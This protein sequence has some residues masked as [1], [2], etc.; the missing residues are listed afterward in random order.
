MFGAGSFSPAFSPVSLESCS[1][2]VYNMPSAR[3]QSKSA[4][5]D[6][7]NS[8]ITKLTSEYDEV[9]ARNEELTYENAR[10][11]ADLRMS[12]AARSAQRLS[13]PAPDAF[14]VDMLR[15]RRP[16]GILKNGSGV[17]LDVGNP[18]M[19]SSN[20]VAVDQDQ[21]AFDHLGR[22]VQITLP[23]LQSRKEPSKDR[24]I[25]ALACL[26]EP[27]S[28]SAIRGCEEEE[29]DKV[30]DLPVSISIEEV[31][32]APIP[33]ESSEDMNHLI[34]KEEAFMSGRT[35]SSSDG[36]R[37]SSKDRR[38]RP[39][40]KDRHGFQAA[41][42]DFS[43]DAKAPFP[44]SPCH[45]APPDGAQQQQILLQLLHQQQ[46]FL[47]QLQRNGEAAEHSPVVLSESAWTKE[48]DTDPAT[49][50][51]RDTSAPTYV[52]TKSTDSVTSELELLPLWTAETNKTQKRRPSTSSLNSEPGSP[53]TR[54]RSMS[55]VVSLDK[56]GAASSGLLHGGLRSG[57]VIFAK[58][59]WV[60]RFMLNPNGWCSMTWDLISVVFVIWDLIT[61]PLQVFALD[62]IILDVADVLVASVWTLD[63]LLSFLRGVTDGGALDMRPR[64]VAVRY[65]RSWFLM[66]VG[67]VFTDWMLIASNGGEDM[68]FLRVLRGRIVLRMLRIFRLLRIMK[69]VRSDTNVLKNVLVSDNSKALAGILNLMGIICL[70]NHYVACG[71]F[72]VG[73][74]GFKHNWIE[75]FLHDGDMLDHYLTA[76]HWSV[77][78]FTPASMDVFSI[79]TL[80]RFYNVII[81]VLGMVMFSTFVSSMTA[82]MNH[83]NKLNFEQR[84]RSLSLRQY[85]SDNR[86]SLALLNCILS[87]QKSYKQKD[88][89]RLHEGDV[90]VF[91]TLPEDLLQKLHEEVYGPI[92]SW[93]PL[94]HHLAD[95]EESIVCSLCHLAMSEK[96]LVIGEELFRSGMR[97]SKMYFVTSGTLAY[98]LGYDEQIPQLVEE[99]SWICEP[100]L[101]SPWTHKGRL[102]IATN[103]NYSDYSNEKALE[104]PKAP[105]S[106]F[107]GDLMV[108]DAPEFH[109]IISQTRSLTQMQTYA[110]IYSAMAV[111]D[112]GGA[113]SIDDLWGSVSQIETCLQRAFG[114]G[115]E[116][117]AASKLMMLWDTGENTWMH[118]F[119]TWKQAAAEEREERR[120]DE[121]KGWVGYYL[122]LIFGRRRRRA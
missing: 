76:F 33:G 26:P 83:L 49:D 111:Q 88:K 102:T 7:F 8:L 97:G 74:V 37:P 81:I 79:N 73:S 121:K 56:E 3:R 100:V 78:Q 93:H 118:C 112:C 86:V 62:H 1:K 114:L 28:E 42:T 29:D 110:R 16:S 91:K 34:G 10:L 15:H 77:T 9:C 57:D 35:L 84:N 32:P 59:T 95:T 46:Q 45:L 4:Q 89:K 115:E 65:L 31:P 66:D 107:R 21:G 80:E 70:I 87:Y 44:Q 109:T 39:S 103:T 92:L 25:A 61:I 64:R 67:V 106:G 60:G 90:A 82:A 52:R 41:G 69:F 99:N 122:G 72:A 19:L 38:K 6:D 68:E 85:V 120:K 75:T 30:P 18:Q 98:F 71:W 48:S 101:W 119:S 96:S 54:I 11:R 43:N 40:S 27:A 36:K 2:P 5:S 20:R 63:I 117:Q 58:K 53:V 94:F 14:R 108:L 24:A 104:R 105:R 50:A 12:A 22:P 47:Q 113:A 23:P 17:V 55:S 116:A 51:D 13:N